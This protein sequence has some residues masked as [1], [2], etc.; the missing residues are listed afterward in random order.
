MKHNVMKLIEYTTI[1][2]IAL[3]FLGP[4]IWMFMQSLK[5]PID[6]ISIPPKIFFSPTFR[7]YSSVLSNPAFF[8]SLKNSL[9]IAAV[10][11]TLTAI[12]GTP[13]GYALARFRFKGSKHLG[14]FILSTMI[15]PPIVILIPLSR[16]YSALHILDTM[17]GLVFVHILMNLALVV[18]VMR[19]FFVGI[20]ISIEE[21]ARIDGCT[22]LQ[23]FYKVVL[24]LASPGLAA[25]TILSFI[26][27]WNDLIYALVL[28]S[29]E[30]CT[31]PIFVSTEFIGFLSVRW[32]ELS[33]ASVLIVLPVI[34]LL[35]L[36][37]KHL[38]RGLSFGAVK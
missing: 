32:G 34:I 30:I 22:H 31:I 21:A 19:S 14:F 26:F 17:L 5:T 20:P 24:P 8:S 23:A 15:L 2:I 25:V 28:T 11:A 29:S 36:V 35:V 38:T 18:W 37:R 12:I 7:N 4:V 1:T 6:S 3:C 27:S 13:F 16:I 10:S 9:I 33:A